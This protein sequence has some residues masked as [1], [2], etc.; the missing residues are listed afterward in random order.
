MPDTD[1]FR[2]AERLLRLAAETQADGAAT[3]IA[4]A[5]AHATL[6]VASRLGAPAPERAPDGTP[7]LAKLDDP[8]FS[9]D[10]D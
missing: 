7:R 10:D 4:R 9:F 6:A 2:E 3:L 5:H 1:H 8:D